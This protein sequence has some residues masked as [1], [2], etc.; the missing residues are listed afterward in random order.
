VARHDAVLGTEDAMTRV[1]V[2][3]A[4]VLLIAPADAATMTPSAPDK[5]A[6]P[7]D[8]QKMQVCQNR[9]AAQKVPMA[10]R[11]KFVMDCMARM[12]K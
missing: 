9:A 2:F 11:S 5:M 12:A 4:A 6:S 3:V 8:K 10:E 7:S 1:F